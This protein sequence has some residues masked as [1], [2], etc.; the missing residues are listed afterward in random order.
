MMWSAPGQ[1]MRAQDGWGQIPGMGS[2]HVESKHMVSQ[3]QV[4]KQVLH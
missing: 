3:E 1:R 2:E 4:K